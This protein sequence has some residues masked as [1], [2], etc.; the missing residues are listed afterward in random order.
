MNIWYSII[1]LLAVFG[2]L[3]CL[4]NQQE[5]IVIDHCKELALRL[6]LPDVTFKIDRQLDGAGSGY[7]KVHGLYDKF[8]KSITLSDVIAGEIFTNL[9]EEKFSIADYV[10]LHELGHHHD[11]ISGNHFKRSTA[12]VLATSAVNALLCYLWQ[13][14]RLPLM[15]IIIGAAALSN[16]F[17][18]WVVSSNYF[19]ERYA[20]RFA[21]RALCQTHGYDVTH[22][23]MTQLSQV[24]PHRPVASGYQNWSTLA[25]YVKQLE[26]RLA[27]DKLQI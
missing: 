20:D 12:S 23:F 21:T 26:K 9:K 10:V 24:D 19:E 3:N 17:A 25:T 2:R 13:D 11:F 14:A 6:N 4:N 18:I 1:F 27:H 7:D 8:Q 5:G 16:C 15:S 22:D